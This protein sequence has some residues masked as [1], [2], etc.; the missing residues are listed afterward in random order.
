MVDAQRVCAQA[1]TNFHI[2]ST[3]HPHSFLYLLSSQHFPQS[4]NAHRKGSRAPQHSQH[5]TVLPSLLSAS[6]YNPLIAYSTRTHAMPLTKSLVR[7]ASLVASHSTTSTTSA[8]SA[9]SASHIPVIPSP[10]N[11]R[12]LES[13]EPTIWILSLLSNS[14]SSV[15]STPPNGPDIDP[16]PSP[17]QLRKKK[18]GPDLRRKVLLK[19]HAGKI[20]D[21]EGKRREREERKERNEREARDW[22]G[23]CGVADGGGMWLEHYD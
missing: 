21:R 22:L 1:A 5:P 16:S 18:S 14:S 6:Q 10:L 19:A 7:R 13:L 3:V 15:S 8:L 23:R 12:S 9:L 20:R 11:P 2:L 17:A 4:R